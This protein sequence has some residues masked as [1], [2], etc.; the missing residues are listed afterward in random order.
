MNNPFLLISLI[1]L[2]YV[3]AFRGLSLVR[4]EGLSNQFVCEGIGVTGFILLVMYARDVVMHPFYFLIL[5][6]L[7]TM[8]ARLL[9]D[10][11]NR[12]SAWGRGRDA[13]AV[14]NFALRC[15]PD[16][17]T[18]L[19][20]LLNVG[21]AYL[22]GQQP[23]C[24]IDVLAQVKG[25]LS[26]Q[27]A[28]KYRASCCYNLGMAY[29]RVGRRAEALQQFREVAEIAPFSDYARLAERARDATLNDSEKSE[30][31]KG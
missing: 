28:P 12:L 3:L 5:L 30:T 17:P 7:I 25:Q 29:R 8:R 15:F 9:V 14:Y 24:A 6:Y 21:A 19:I 2:L 1:G 13:L 22:T 26:Q 20:V 4:R 16:Q 11:G 31:S 18:R 23:E 10:L 27:F